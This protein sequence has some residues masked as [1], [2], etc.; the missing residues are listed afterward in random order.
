MAFS[1]PHEIESTSYNSFIHS[2]VLNKTQ[3]QLGG[4]YEGTHDSVY[5]STEMN[6][7]RFMWMGESAHWYRR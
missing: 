2:H 5:K 3:R 1:Y 6:K 4:G 7:E